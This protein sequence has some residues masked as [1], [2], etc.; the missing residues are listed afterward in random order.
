MKLLNLENKMMIVA[1]PMLT[2]AGYIDN[3]DPEG[4]KK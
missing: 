4:K 3:N 2:T 1:D